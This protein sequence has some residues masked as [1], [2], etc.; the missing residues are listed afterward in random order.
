MFTAKMNKAIF[1]LLQND[2]TIKRAAYG[3]FVAK[4]PRRKNGWSHDF[5]LYQNINNDGTVIATK[6]DTRLTDFYKLEDVFFDG[7]IDTGNMEFYK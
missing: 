1:T 7:G 4:P 5:T 6:G 2:F 3:I